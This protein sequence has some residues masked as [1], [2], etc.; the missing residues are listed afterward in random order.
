MKETEINV[1]NFYQFIMWWIY[2]HRYSITSKQ[3]T[4]AL[5]NEVIHFHNDSFNIGISFRDVFRL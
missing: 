1:G 2:L 3:S 4:K 5:L